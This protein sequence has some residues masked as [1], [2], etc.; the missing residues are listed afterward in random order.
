[1]NVDISPNTLISVGFA[2]FSALLVVILQ[3]QTERLK[4]VESQL[5]QSKYKVYH[6]LVSIFFD[7]LKDSKAGRALDIDSLTAKMLDI[8]KHIFIYGSDKT[9][10]LLSKWLQTSTTHPDSLKHVTFFL[11]LLISVRK[12]M[13]HRNTKM[14]QKDIMLLIMQNEAEYD[15]LK[16]LL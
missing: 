7:M 3:R 15:K 10:L 8:K 4:I 1:M 2:L 5:A 9:I 6:E 12:D 14:T 11:D 13:G 16:E